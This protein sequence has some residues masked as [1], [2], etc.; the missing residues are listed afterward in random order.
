MWTLVVVIALGVRVVVVLIE[1]I[2]WT[3][4][5]NVNKPPKYISQGQN[6]RPRIVNVYSPDILKVKGCTCCIN[7]LKKSDWNK[8]FYHQ[9][10]QV[11]YD[12]SKTRIKHQKYDWLNY[13]SY[14]SN[15][16]QNDLK[17]TLC[18]RFEHPN[19]PFGI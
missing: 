10:I 14:C 9:I 2:F 6:I 18:F 19:I 13:N 17:N 8:V 16:W 4:S 7:I 15:K 12:Q 5:M 1:H 3:D 11:L